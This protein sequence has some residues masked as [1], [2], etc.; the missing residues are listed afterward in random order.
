MS[1]GCPWQRTTIT[2]CSESSPTRLRFSAR[3]TYLLQC[4]ALCAAAALTLAEMLTGVAALA[5]SLGWT[6]A[7]AP[8]LQAQEML[9]HRSVKVSQAESRAPGKQRRKTK[10]LA[11][12]AYSVMFAQ[13]A[14][15][16]IH[17]YKNR[18]VAEAKIV[19]NCHDFDG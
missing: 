14:N 8:T 1:P 17:S 3:E 5:T 2:R 10:T 11:T 7:V 15:S 13:R 4:A 16:R 19:K 9:L 18:I 6:S 12:Q